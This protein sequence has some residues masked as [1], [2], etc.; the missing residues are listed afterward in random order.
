MSLI[1]NAALDKL[2]RFLEFQNLFDFEKKFGFTTKKDYEIKLVFS[3]F[4]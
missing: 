2:I 4:I 1:L 3:L